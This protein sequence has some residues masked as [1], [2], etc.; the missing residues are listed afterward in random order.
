MYDGFV[1]RARA[2]TRLLADDRSTFCVVTTLEPAPVREA[3][4]F[5]DELTGGELHLGAVIVNKSLP[6][7]LLHDGPAAVAR[8]SGTT[9]PTLAATAASA[10]RGAGRPGRPGAGRGGRELR[11]LRR[12]RHA[13]RPSSAPSWPPPQMRW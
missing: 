6:E 11:Q 7:W 5:V 1:E 3:A 2:V 8:R 13:A 9:P 12:R 4:F 10:G